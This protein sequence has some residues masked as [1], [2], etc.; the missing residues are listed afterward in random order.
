MRR[1]LVLAIAGVVVLFVALSVT[2]W[3]GLE[4]I[5]ADRASAGVL[6]SAQRY[7]QD[8]DM[9]HDALRSD[10]LAAALIAST[11]SGQAIDASDDIRSDVEEHAAQLHSDLMQ[12]KSLAVAGD[13]GKLLNGLRPGLEAYAIEAQRIVDL[14][15]SNP[16]AVHQP[17]QVFEGT[18]LRLEV[19]QA[20]AT[21]KVAAAARHAR[22]DAGRAQ[23]DAERSLL[24]AGALAL[25][26][27]VGL[28]AWLGRLGRWTRR[29]V[30]EVDSSRGRSLAD[31]EFLSATLESLQDGIVACDSHGVL[32]LFNA[33]TERLHGLPVESVP[34]EQWAEHFD[35]FAADGTTP[36]PMEEIPLLRALN[37]ELVDSVNM[38]IAPH[39]RPRRFVQ[40]TGRAI[41]DAAGNKLG[42]VV[43]MHDVTE[44]RAAEA[45]LI[46]QAFTDP[47]TG[48]PNRALFQDR[49]EQADARSDRHLSFLGLLFLDIDDFKA[50]NDTMGHEAGDEV[51][52]VI[53]DRIRACARPTDTVAR[54]GGDE[55]AVLIEDA[56]AGADDLIAQ[57][58]MASVRLPIDVSGTR[59][60]VTV[61]MGL[62]SNGAGGVEAAML[63]QSADVAMY[64]AKS[65]GK[66]QYEMFV[67]AMLEAVQ[68][69]YDLRGELRQAIAEK[70]FVVYYQPQIELRSGSIVGVE[71]LVRWHHPTRGL[72]APD[73]FIALAEETGLIIT[74]DDWVLRTALAQ[75][76]QWN[77]TSEPPLRVA[78]NLSGHHFQSGGLVDR[79]TAALE[80]TSF[81]PALLEVEVTETAAIEEAVA[82][83]EALKELRALGIS[84]AI[85]DFGTGYSMLS[86]LQ[87][88]PLDT[89][90]IDR[91]FVRE[92]TL[93]RLNCP[94]I[95]GM[96]AMATGLGL[97]VVAEGI[98]TV[99]Q[100]R[101]LQQ[102]GC[103][104]GQGYLFSRPLPPDALHALLG[105][106]M[107][108]ALAPT[109]HRLP[110]SHQA[111]VAA[112]T[113][114]EITRP[115][116]AELERLTGLE[117][118][119]LTEIHWLSDE[120]EVR[121]ARNTATLQIP[122][123]LR[124]DWSDTLCRRV[125]LEGGPQLTNDVPGVY[126][127]SAI[128]R[129][130]GLQTYVSVPVYRDDGEVFGTL[131][132]AS[133]ASRDLDGTTTRLME[134]FAQ[135]LTQHI[136][137]RATVT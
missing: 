60:S 12:I 24:I 14:A 71:A 101:F 87:D 36:M 137:H 20:D 75:V 31:Q 82:A 91:S 67:P 124:A 52:R 110:V 88:F 135:Q 43:A 133:V 59:V 66:D 72:V 55:F 30:R 74:I 90:K 118:T 39:D 122:E 38:V 100:L 93:D 7:H 5:R 132:G 6:A 54:L 47:L 95:T 15:V 25:A 9:M 16:S 73:E 8:A 80:E 92:I 2:S 96:L 46:R 104:Q 22:S 109:E 106:S 136:E 56:D 13:I 78:V 61:S 69:R 84:I 28:I 108:P 26:C 19:S 99:A 86:R 128:A 18:F 123:G 41:R 130:L 89:L 85:D 127:D 45:E 107:L 21:V 131:C 125:L 40:A 49:L 102:Q 126:P 42:A 58:I 111:S 129:N 27:L 117:S 17:L 68:R 79:I 35:L 32:T 48:F 62:A 34:A 116:L 65:R 53:A 105:T 94:L 121:Y 114:E 120:Q 10:V 64:V 50:I 70:Q 77:E 23:G 134:L 97:N 51:L 119:Y 76:R 29:L 103:Q 11:P 115:L 83:S 44:N 4:S 112:S 57:R 113:L 63:L 37:G 1:R 33:A 81:D 3:T 98:E